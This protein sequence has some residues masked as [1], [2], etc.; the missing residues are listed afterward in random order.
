MKRFSPLFS[1]LGATAAF[2]L[3]L[4]GC[5]SPTQTAQN[6]ESSPSP[7]A[8]GNGASGE[9]S[10]PAAIATVAKDEKITVAF[11]TNN[12][13]DFWTIA[14]K[15]CAKA[16]A[17]LPNLEFEFRMP[18]K[19]TAAEQ[20]NIVN[21][22]LAKG[23][24]GI[25]ISPTDPAN[26]TQMLNKTA[27]QA[28][29]LTQDS[30]APESKRACYVGTDN[31]AA[32]RQ[33]GE[34]IKKALPNGGKIMVF[35]GMKDAQNGQDRYNGIKEVLQGSKVEII[36]LRTDDTNRTKAKANAADT[37]VKYP[38]VAALVGL[39]SYNGPA[40][41]GAVKDA[42][43]IGKVKIICFDE[44]TPTLAGVRSGAIS[45]TVVQQPYKFGYESLKLMDKVLREGAGA[46]P[47]GNMQ[48]VP[49]KII[50]KS[51]VD[52]FEKELKVLRAD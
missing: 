28:V 7:A 2:S 45:A 48:I 4:T 50:T 33:A 37:L 1:V 49:T 34:E 41:L 42:G 3:A 9:T 31:K 27:E 24:K 18:A 5:N 36:D 35:V 15:G 52:A 6:G 30:D 39:W 21:D 12:T 22:L 47:E 40:I 46:I 19:G 43:K 10:A 32:G 44:E 8:T 17:E 14:K 25:A 11:V 20:Q 26:Q 23:I 51:N 16:D 29:L 13:S 38:D